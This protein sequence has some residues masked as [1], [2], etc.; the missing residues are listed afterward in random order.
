MAVHVPPS[1]HNSDRTENR[2][3]YRLFI[4][5]SAAV[6]SNHYVRMPLNFQ[7]QISTKIHHMKDCLSPKS[8]TVCTN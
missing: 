2:V 1:V 6:Y 4:S 3:K 5:K 8:T 7:I